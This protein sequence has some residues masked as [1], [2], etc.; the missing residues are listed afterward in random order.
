MRKLPQPIIGRLFKKYQ[1]T[2]I[3]LGLLSSL[4]FTLLINPVQAAD[5]LVDINVMAMPA[6]SAFEVFGTQTGFNLEFSADEVDGLT[7]KA[8]SGS[9]SPERALQIMLAESGLEATL[10]DNKTFVIS[11]EGDLSRTTRLSQADAGT[12]TD[13]LALEEV[14]VTGTQIKGAAISEALS[15]S[16]ISA[17]DIDAFGISSG[18][19]LLES[20]TEQGQNFQSEAENIAGGVNSVRGDIGAFNLRNMGTGNTLVLLNGRRTI[21]AAG[22]QTEEIGGS[23]VPVNT[24]NS[25]TIPVMGVRRVEVLRDG[26]SA[27][28]GADA[29]AGVVNTVL[30]N[31][32]D[33]LTVR[34]RYDWYDNIPRNDIRLNIE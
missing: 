18:D 12:E 1:K 32:F 11:P 5:E 21:Q 9:M 10:V 31:N 17:E 8:V 7:S 20:M 3:N 23:F 33:G 6:I 25:N 34:A 15:V 28:Y 4:L 19:G 16:V 30:K 2:S 26:A 14:V 22:Y 13:E 29:V 24:S 27:I